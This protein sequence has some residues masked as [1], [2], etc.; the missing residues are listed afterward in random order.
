MIV[1][2]SVPDSLYYSI[3]YPRPYNT[4]L[5]YTFYNVQLSTA[6]PSLHVYHKHVV[7]I[8]YRYNYGIS[9]SVRQ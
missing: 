6:S 3:E 1:M 8:R 5:N 2:R 4:L 7:F 9:N